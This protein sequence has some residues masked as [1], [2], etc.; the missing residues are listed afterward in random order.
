MAEVTTAEF[1]EGVRRLA[2]YRP[3]DDGGRG[4]EAVLR[5]LALSAAELNGGGFSRLATCQTGFKDLWDIED[6]V[7]ELRK[8]RDSLVEE[9]LA[10]AA[11]GG[12]TLRPEKRE[13]LQ[14]TATETEKVEEVALLQWERSTREQRPDLAA[15]DIAD[16]RQ[17]LAEWL[18]K[19]VARHG[20]E[21]ALMLYPEETRAHRL[22]D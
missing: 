19:V 20:A 22:F 6:E 13:A 16:L 5:D 15:D 17:D 11:G 1:N 14:S 12:F 21:A 7:E 8:V 3:F 10:D 9:R 4:L 18:S 2:Q